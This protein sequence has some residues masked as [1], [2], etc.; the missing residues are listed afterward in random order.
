VVAAA[1]TDDAADAVENAVKAVENAVKAVVNAQNALSAL[2]VVT[3]RIPVAANAPKAA[4]LA[5]V[6]ATDRKDRAR[7]RGW[8][9]QSWQKHKTRPTTTLTATPV[10]VLRDRRVSAVTADAVVVAVVNARLQVRRT[11]RH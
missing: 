9:K 3:N 5:A 7:N 1:P 10:S 6:A 11:T 8:M 4:A 2:I